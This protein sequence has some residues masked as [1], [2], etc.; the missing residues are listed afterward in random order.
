MLR[1]FLYSLYF[2]KIN[3]ENGT[4][5]A[6]PPLDA[7]AGTAAGTTGA[8]LAL[9]SRCAALAH[10]E[11]VAVVVE[12]AAEAAGATAVRCP[13]CARRPL[14]AGALV[15]GAQI[16]GEVTLLPLETKGGS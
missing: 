10:A 13:L 8:T 14:G 7:G 1:S 4:V 16:G 2:F 5:G 9:P 15:P 3:S 6:P 12:G 11:D